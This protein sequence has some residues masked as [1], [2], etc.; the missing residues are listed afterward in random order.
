MATQVIAWTVEK[1]TTPQS[2]SRQTIKQP[3]FFYDHTL[4]R[5]TMNTLLPNAII[6]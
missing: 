5:A 1:H 3:R 4:C 2:P 6:K